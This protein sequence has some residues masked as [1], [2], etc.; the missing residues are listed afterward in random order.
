MTVLRLASQYAQPWCAV[1]WGRASL[2]V[3]KFEK[4][5]LKMAIFSVL[6]IPFGVLNNRFKDRFKILFSLKGLFR[7]QKE[8]FKT[9]LGP[10]LCFFCWYYSWLQ[11]PDP[12]CGPNVVSVFKDIGVEEADAAIV[13]PRRDAWCLEPTRRHFFGV[14]NSLEAHLRRWPLVS[15][16]RTHWTY[17]Q[18]EYS[19]A[20]AG[21]CALAFAVEL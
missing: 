5:D 11:W 17:V 12:Q 19:P 18:R 9:I 3:W 20:W 13:P 10:I 7:G 14:G 8:S 1:I 15:F 21:L 16:G 4:R 2:S 6:N